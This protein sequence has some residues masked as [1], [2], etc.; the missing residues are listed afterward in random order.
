LRE[1]LLFQA[2]VLIAAAE[3]SVSFH[4]G[5]VR[6]QAG[7]ATGAGGGEVLPAV[8]RGAVHQEATDLRV[9]RPE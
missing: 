3:V 4:F 9:D 5:K 1:T 7:L 8:E 6:R 2:E